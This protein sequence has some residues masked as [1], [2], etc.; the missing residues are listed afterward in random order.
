MSHASIGL[1]IDL[2]PMLRLQTNLVHV[3]ILLIVIG[4]DFEA[5]EESKYGF[6]P[7]PPQKEETVY[8][9]PELTM[10]VLPIAHQ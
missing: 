10:T 7:H 1:S 3:K 9:I 5:S 2:L 4:K 8:Q 6:Q